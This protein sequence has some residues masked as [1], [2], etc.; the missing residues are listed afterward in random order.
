MRFGGMVDGRVGVG[1]CFGWA[2]EAG[3]GSVRYR[4]ITF[5]GDGCLGLLACMG[6]GREGLSMETV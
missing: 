2:V 3:E 4:G 1:M 6:V 5:V